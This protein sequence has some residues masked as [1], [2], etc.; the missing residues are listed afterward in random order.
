M[1]HI[2]HN[3]GIIRPRGDRWQAD[4]A[5]HGRRQRAAHT[6]E[7][8][9]RA[10]IDARM[11]ELRREI[12]AT[13][14]R[15][16]LDAADARAILPV[17][18]SLM[19]AAR[20]YAAR[21]TAA[22]MAGA[23]VASLY[24]RYLADKTA[25]G[26]RPRSIQSI[27]TY[28][29]RLARA[30]PDAPAGGVSPVAL[31][32]ILAAGRY[33]PATRNTLRRYWLGFFDYAR[34]LG[35]C[36]DNPAAGIPIS[37]LDATMPAILTP[38]QAAALLHAAPARFKP[39]LAVGLFAGLRTSELLELR[40]RDVSES[41]IRVI[42]AVAK[43][44]RQR[45]IPILPVLAPWLAQSGPPDARLAPVQSRRWHTVMRSLARQIGMDAWP[46]NAMRHSFASY[47]L[48]VCQDAAKTALILGYSGDAGVFWNHYRELTTEADAAKYFAPGDKFVTNQRQNSMELTRVDKTDTK[49]KPRITPLKQGKCAVLL[50]KTPV[51]QLDRAADS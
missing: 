42:P 28:C 2:R 33:G 15:L 34:R 40:W 23:T 10:W 39:A 26:L 24:A 13:S 11:L 51:A 5:H 16:A 27:K 47:H 50:D 18:V 46:A 37:R 31:A 38:P 48:T 44:R 49:K 43:R 36:V 6:T 14:P 29:G 32:D 8:D 22:P 3:G 17:G 21:H 30:M 9:A 35:A 45:L 41:H 7:A 1:R 25:A 20:E 19:D 4:I 12:P